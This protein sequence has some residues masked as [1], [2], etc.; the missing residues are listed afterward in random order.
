MKKLV[1]LAFRF[2]HIAITTGR[3]KE[4]WLTI[5]SE[6]SDS[7]L[8]RDGDYFLEARRCEGY[9]YLRIF[10]LSPFG[11]NVSGA[12]DELYFPEGKLF[13]A[14]F[15]GVETKLLGDT[16]LPDAHPQIIYNGRKTMKNV[17]ANKLF[18]HK[19]AKFMSCHFDWRNSKAIHLYDDGKYSFYFEEEMKGGDRGI[20]GGVIL[21]NADDPA[22]AYYGMHT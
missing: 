17:A 16:E 6:E 5:P 10:W 2:N 4:F 11:E 19:F 13:Y 9:D 14:I 18:R 1:K 3:H 21:H 8:D 12:V 20:C 7:I 22:K 15:Y